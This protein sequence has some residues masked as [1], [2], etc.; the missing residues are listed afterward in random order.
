MGSPFNSSKSAYAILRFIN[1][2]AFAPVTRAY[3]ADT[4]A[5]PREP[6]CKNSITHPPH[7]IPP[8]LGL[9]V[10]NVRQNDTLR[11]SE[12]GNGLN[13]SNAALD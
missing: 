8:R 12:R 4:L 13:E 2:F 6:H 11:I 5:P 9:A 3:D 7:A 10:G 1:S